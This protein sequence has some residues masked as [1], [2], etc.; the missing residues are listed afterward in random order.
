MDDAELIGVDVMEPLPEDGEA[1]DSF[2]ADCRAPVSV[3]R[4]SP[5]SLPSGVGV[6]VI[7]PD[8]HPGVGVDDGLGMYFSSN[9]FT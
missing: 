5:F 3:F 8:L 6:G 7:E 9:I 1:V 2:W 4:V